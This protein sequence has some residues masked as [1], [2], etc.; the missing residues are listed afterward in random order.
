MTP[1]YT[2]IIGLEIH[3]ELK[4]KSKMFCACKNDPD[5]GAPNTNICPVCLAHP[6]TLPVPNATALTDIVKI[7]TA[8]GCKI[9]TESKFDRKHY[10]YPDLPKA[11]QIS[12]FDQPVGEHGAIVLNLITSKNHRDTARIGITRVHMEEDTAK[13]THGASH[14][15][16]PLLGQEGETLVDFNRA[17]VPLVEIVSDPD[18]QSGIEAKAYCQELQTIFRYL[19]VSNADMEKGQMRCEA[20]V[21]VQETGKFVDEAGVI[22]P[23]GDYKLNNKVEVKNINSFRAVEKAIDFEIKRQTA[24]IEKGEAWSQQTRGWSDDKGETVMQRIKE[25]SADY[26]YFPEPD[27]P[28]FNPAKIAGNIELPELPAQKRARFHEEYGF[29]YA[30]AAILATDPHWA[31]YAED[32]YSDLVEWLHSLPVSVPPSG[33]TPG[34]PENKKTT[35]EILDNK[36]SALAKLTG[37]WLTS[38]LMGA[39]AERKIDI[40]ILKLSAENFSELLALFYTGRVNSTN[41]AKILNEMLDANTDIDPTHIMEEKGY[42][43]M[44]DE[45]ALGKIVDDVIASHPEQVAKFK[46]GKEPLLQFLKGMVMKATEGAA[47]PVVAEK[48]L[49][50]KMK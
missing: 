43:Q 27:I 17:G 47:D 50:E 7:A 48:L 5:H 18:I 20:N 6:G 40:R 21:S 13:L 37:N 28:P 25:T 46:A 11:Y 39:M 24:M 29:S 1:K 42:G 14:H 8:L 3:V 38:K 35:S 33:T 22:K 19:G 31:T 49:R 34:K 45:G 15:P 16:S 23:I 9:A 26:R 36:K 12:Q 41:A 30:D 10:F 44:S 32:V 2:T 4:T